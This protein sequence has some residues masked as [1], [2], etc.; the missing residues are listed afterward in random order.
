MFSFI[1]SLVVLINSTNRIPIT[2][3]LRNFAIFCITV[4]LLFLLKMLYEI[5]YRTFGKN[6]LIY[7]PLII[8][9]IVQAAFIID[10]KGSLINKDSLD[11]A[12][13]YIVYVA[14]VILY[15][16]INRILKKRSDTRMVVTY[17]DY[18]GGF[19]SPIGEMA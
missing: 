15:K 16:N 13:V 17:D 3:E 19:L 8:M 2:Q 5:Y 6:K 10:N 1:L 4:D 7:L 18:R 9:G 12:I 14:L 11:L